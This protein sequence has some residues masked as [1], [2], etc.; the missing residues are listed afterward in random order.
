VLAVG[1]AEFQSKALGKMKDVS[2]TQGRTVLFVSHNIGAIKTLCNTA[3]LMKNGNLELMGDTQNIIDC[4]LNAGEIVK[5]S[6]FINE[7]PKKDSDILEIKIV[8]ENGKETSH[9][10]F[11]ESVVVQ[12]K[13]RIAKK[14]QDVMLS[15]R[16]KDQLE[17]NIFTSETKA[18]EFLEKD[19]VLDIKLEI[20]SKVL[21]PNTYQLVVALHKPNVE[22]IQ[23]LDGIVGYTIEETGTNFF[24]YSGNDYG[25]VFVQCKWVNH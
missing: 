20:P 22:V 18:S 8:N 24:Q 10:G 17:R 3:I 6:H 25:C 21:V 7:I 11:D 5:K 16:V 9:F 2:N 23:Y 4:Y 12:F 1:D 19:G 15:V 13:I 14:H